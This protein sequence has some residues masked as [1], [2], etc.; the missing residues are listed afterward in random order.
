ML[1]RRML[2]SGMIVLRRLIRPCI[3][4]VRDTGSQD[5]HQGGSAIH[6]YGSRWPKSGL[7]ADSWAAS[8]SPLW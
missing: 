8:R 7:A 5:E 3:G 2:M 6:G 4:Q 1:V